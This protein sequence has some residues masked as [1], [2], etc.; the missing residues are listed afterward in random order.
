MNRA[1]LHLFALAVGI[2]LQA[3]ELPLTLSQDHKLSL[4]GRVGNSYQF[5]SSTNWATWLT[6]GPF[7]FITN[8]PHVRE[9]DVD[10]P[11]EFYRAHAL[12]A[13]TNGTVPNSCPEY[14]YVTVYHQGDVRGFSIIATHPQFDFSCCECPTNWY[15]CPT[16]TTSTDYTNGAPHFDHQK[17]FDDGT[18]LLL[19]NRLSAFWRPHGMF[20]FTNGVLCDTNEI[21]FIELARKIPDTN[22]WPTFGA[23]YCESYT[24]WIPFPP[25]GYSNVCMGISAVIG[26]AVI[27]ERP[28]ADIYSIDY[29]IASQTLFVTYRNGG[30]ATLD[31]STVTRSNAIVKARLGVDFPTDKPFVTIRSMWVSDTMCDVAYVEWVDTS[32][33]SHTNSI[34]SFPGGIGTEWF[35]RRYTPSAHTPSAPSIRIILQ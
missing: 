17:V 21:H 14:D 27:A 34:M 28:Y 26:P 22:Q 32:S 23:I 30:T 1:S 29:R 4:Y 7:F 16:N 18:N 25:L 24:R 11:Q 2:N 13:A 33:I 31:V 9:I 20:V 3:V 15:G 19:I 35:Y 12:I 6:N 5:E 10:K 8:I